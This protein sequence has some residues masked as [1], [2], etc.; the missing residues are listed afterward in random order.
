MAGTS[1][2]MTGRA[3]F[4]PSESNPNPSSQERGGEFAALAQPPAFSTF[5]KIVTGATITPDMLL[6]IANG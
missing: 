3:V 2:A 4:G 6:R 1:P 5:Q